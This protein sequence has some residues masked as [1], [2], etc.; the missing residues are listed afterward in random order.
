V[1]GLSD[2][3]MDIVFQRMV[4]EPAVDEIEA[5]VRTL[6]ADVQEM[7]GVIGANQMINQRGAWGKKIGEGGAEWGC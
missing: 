6:G 1:A 7:A 5:A 2:S 4:W 3:T